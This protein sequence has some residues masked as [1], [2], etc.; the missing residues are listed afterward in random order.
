M[1][2]VLQVGL[3]DLDALQPARAL[4]MQIGLGDT[5]TH[6]YKMVQTPVCTI[7]RHPIAKKMS[8]LNVQN[9]KITNESIES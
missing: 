3:N 9:Q 1:V 2:V 4:C 8:E 6:T 7:I 5:H